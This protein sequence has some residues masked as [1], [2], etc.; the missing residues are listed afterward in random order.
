MNTGR[1]QNGGGEGELETGSVKNS[2]KKSGLVGDW[3]T[4]PGERDNSSQR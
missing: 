1:D 3:Q 2:K 4:G